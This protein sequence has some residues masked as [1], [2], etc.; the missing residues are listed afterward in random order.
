MRKSCDLF[1]YIDS[2]KAMEAGL[3][4]QKSANG[5]ILTAGNE[6]GVVPQELFEK[7]VTR[8]GEDLMART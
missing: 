7:A 6:A 1:I 5:V 3:K 2:A 8:D 4:F